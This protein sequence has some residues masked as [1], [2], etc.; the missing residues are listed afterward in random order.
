VPQG[1]ARLRQ[2]FGATP[3]DHEITRHA[4]IVS[5]RILAAA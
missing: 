3:P 5:T 4:R 1:T 2:T